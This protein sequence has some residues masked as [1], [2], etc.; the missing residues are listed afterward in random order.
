[1]RPRVFAA[2]AELSVHELTELGRGIR[3][4]ERMRVDLIASPSD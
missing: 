3:M 1:M 2:G 4:G